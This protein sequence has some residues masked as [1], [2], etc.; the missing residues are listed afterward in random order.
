[1][2]VHVE[3]AL[4]WSY[5]CLI[6]WLLRVLKLFPC[7]MTTFLFLTHFYLT[8]KKRKPVS[9]GEEHKDS[10]NVLSDLAWVCCSRAAGLKLI[11]VR[12]TQWE[13]PDSQRLPPSSL[14]LQ[15]S[16]PRPTH[17]RDESGSSTGAAAPVVFRSW[18]KI[19]T[20]VQRP[21][22]RMRT[23]NVFCRKSQKRLVHFGWNI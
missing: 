7:F 1:M 5:D 4:Q 14:D 13:K 18:R 6:K 19:D 23:G 16:P 22:G 9:D 20:D 12:E 8:E 10:V 21:Y 15:M 3:L 17:T 11:S 2:P